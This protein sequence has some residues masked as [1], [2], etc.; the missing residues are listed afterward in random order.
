MNY[1]YVVKCWDAINRTVS[2]KIEDA[3][4]LYI[5]H[6]KI[7]EIYNNETEV[8]KV[9]NI[10]N[11]ISVITNYVDK[12]ISDHNKTYFNARLAQKKRID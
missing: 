6:E 12:N 8:L 1:D 2:K 11:I 5:K 9:P 10:E 3:I 7:N 4:K